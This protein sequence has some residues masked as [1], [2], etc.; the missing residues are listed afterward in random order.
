MISLD[1]KKKLKK[2]HFTWNENKQMDITSFGNL[3][4]QDQLETEFDLP[5]K[6]H[7]I[8]FLVS[9]LGSTLLNELPDDCLLKKNKKKDLYSVIPTTE[10]NTL[11]SF[12]RTITP[13][14]HGILGDYQHDKKLNVSYSYTTFLDR[15]LNRDLQVYG[16][17]P[18]EFYLFPKLEKSKKKK[19]YTL[20][21]SSILLMDSY[22]AILEG[23]HIITYHGLDDILSRLKRI[24][25]TNLKGTTTVVY[26]T[27]LETMLQQGRRK[28]EIIKFLKSFTDMA[29][30]LKQKNNMVVVSAL[31]GCSEID[32][33]IVLNYGKYNKYFY[34]L[35]SIAKRMTS[36]YVKKEYEKEFTREFKKDYGHLLGL[37]RMDDMVKSDIFQGSKGLD[38]YG[39][40]ISINLAHNY[41][42]LPISEELYI[43]QLNNP[44][45]MN[46]CSGGMSKDEVIVPLILL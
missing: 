39:E 45:Y 18:K 30:Q 15:T 7:K 22:K 44:N 12:Y 29:L 2:E 33:S 5:L 3:L 13:G 38:N 9:G 26:I 20:F 17:N 36:F 10:L 16:K 34:A 43:E 37:Y 8:I 14:V 24:G 31:H 6:K 40:Y 11:I 46:A 42:E 23:Q 32:A 19:Y 21:P 25:M 1:I 28:E 41:L 4:W 27:E 35:P